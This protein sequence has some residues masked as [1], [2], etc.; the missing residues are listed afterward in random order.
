MNN[1]SNI[2]YTLSLLFLISCTGNQ[3]NKIVWK[4]NNTISLNDIAPIGIVAQGDF[5]WLSDVDHNQLVKIN[6]DG[7]LLEKLK[8]FERPMHLAI[9]QNKIYIPEYTTDKIWILENGSRSKYSLKTK[10]DAIAGV[11]VDQTRIAFADFYNHRVVLQQGDDATIIGKEGHNDGELYYPTD[12]SIKN[13]LLYV[14]DAYNNRVQVFDFN[15][16]YVKMIAWNE[17]IKVATGIKITDTQVIVADFE[18]N[19]ILIYNHAGKLLQTLTNHFDKPADIE[20]KG[21]KMYVVNYG[22]KSIA[23]FENENSKLHTP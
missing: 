6:Q 5:L 19:R 16:N 9:F 21:S 2:I 15:G 13:N 12:V 20:I 7:Q 10:T 11:S 3:K 17:N 1:F 23:V 8:D 4:Y 14:A 22:S 18:G